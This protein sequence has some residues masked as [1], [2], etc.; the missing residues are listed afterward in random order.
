MANCPKCGKPIPDGQEKCPT[1]G[2]GPLDL[3]AGTTAHINLLKKRLE[4]DPTNTKL[5]IE[6]G[7]IYQKHGAFNEALIQYQEAVKVDAKN[8]DAQSKS[9]HIFLRFRELD[10]AERAFVASLHIKPTSMESL[11]G[12]FRA[13]YLQN[14]TAEA[15]VIGE[16]IVKSKPNNVEFHLLMKNLYN[17]KGDK[18]KAFIELLKLES[19]TPNNEKIIKEIALYYKNENNMK[20]LIEY[21]N[22]MTSMQIDDIDLGFNI[23]KHYY[24]NNE[25]NKAIEHLNVL[26]KKNPTPEINIMARAY[27]A[28]T[29]FNAG[30]VTEAKNLVNSIQSSEAGQIDK[31]I[32]KK[33]AAILFEFGK[34]A[35]QANK[36]KQA[37]AYFEK[38]ESF[39]KETGEYGQMLNKVKSETAISSKKIMRK[40][41]I[42]AVGVI[43]VFIIALFVWKSMHNRIIIEIDPA[44]DVVVLIDNKQVAAKPEKPGI[45]SSPTLLVGEYSIVI[46]K[47]GY[48]KWQETAKIEF[49]KHTNLKVKLI[50]IYYFLQL[51]SLPESA[52][53]TIDGKVVG[54]TP[55]MSDRMLAR[56]HTIEIG[57][58]GYSKW[59]ANLTV[60]EKDSVDLGVINLK[61]LAGKWRGMVGKEA[62]RY[63][64]SFNMTIEQTNTDLSIRYY[65]EPKANYTYSGKLKGKIDN[66]EFFAEGQVT[67]KYLKVFYWVTEKKKIVMRG[68]ISDSWEKIEGTHNIEGLGDQ[69]WW[70]APRQ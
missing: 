54:K 6:L 36:V 26:L 68:K 38:A 9:A 7:D 1:C 8:F 15:I 63:N 42:I 3:S 23:G 17:Q 55:F 34:N 11:V 4:Q 27:L 48:K 32:Q 62:Y 16:K 14:K 53:V 60:Q 58:E 61:N 43:I 66:D 25:Y 33:L 41:S 20:K 46:E 39:D 64:A 57:Y 52:D 35:H 13:Y 56:P 19:L 37:I 31:E 22:K 49:G 45:I 10:K 18:D 12:L 67:Y 29:Y 51:T 69:S 2:V 30:D 24:E 5:Y 28:L 59:C 44:E 65:H 70:A 50:P 40:I 21:Y 47:A